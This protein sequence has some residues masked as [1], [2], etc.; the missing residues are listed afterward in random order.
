M[1]LP[2]HCGK[3]YRHDEK[4]KH[5][6]HL[7]QAAEGES[8]WNIVFKMTRVKVKELDFG[9][10]TLAAFSHVQEKHSVS[11]IHSRQVPLVIFQGVSSQIPDTLLLSE[12]DTFTLK[13]SKILQKYLE[14]GCKPVG[15]NLC[16]LM[17]TIL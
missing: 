7:L 8:L 16:I 15:L 4:E 2:G 13:T 5:A 14:Q 3:V 1:S 11:F 12:S 17:F 9:R 6:I 10:P